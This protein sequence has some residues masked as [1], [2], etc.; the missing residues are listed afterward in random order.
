MAYSDNKPGLPG[1]EAVDRSVLDLA[2]GYHQALM[3]EVG[4]PGDQ[5]ISTLDDDFAAQ[6]EQYEARLTGNLLMHIAG[7]RLDEK[8][9]TADRARAVVEAL[10]RIT[11]TPALL[12]SLTG[13]PFSP[14]MATGESLLG[15]PA[16]TN[17][18]PPMPRS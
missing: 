1:G 8:A 12:E 15:E 14:M 4:M 17:K 13:A 10:R 3:Q 5:V 2:S 11:T 9:S 18:K 6:Q 7:V 16:K